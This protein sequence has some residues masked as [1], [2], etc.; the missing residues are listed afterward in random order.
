MEE[1]ALWL[2]EVQM[3]NCRMASIEVDGYV[4]SSIKYYCLCAMI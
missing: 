3:R 4:W 1:H 2:E